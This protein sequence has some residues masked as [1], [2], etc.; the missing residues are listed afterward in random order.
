LNRHRPLAN[1][2]MSLCG[3]TPAKSVVE[4]SESAFFHYH[5]SNLP[6]ILNDIARDDTDSLELDRLIRTLLIPY[7]P[8]IRSELG[9]SFYGFS[10][11]VQIA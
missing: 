1:L 3:C 6:K 5:Y 8:P 4:L 11:D 2:V 7:L 9:V 10:T